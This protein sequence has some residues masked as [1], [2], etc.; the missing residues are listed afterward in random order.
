MK[1]LLA[2]DGG[3]SSTFGMLTTE[4]GAV[5]DCFRASGEGFPPARRGGKVSGQSASSLG[6]C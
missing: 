5:L 3:Q 2:V 6:S 1:V 4:T